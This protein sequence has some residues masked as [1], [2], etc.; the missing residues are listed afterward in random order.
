MIKDFLKDLRLLKCSFYDIDFKSKN[1]LKK[2]KITNAGE[3]LLFI[4]GTG[5][6]YLVEISSIEKVTIAEAENYY[7]K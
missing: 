7:K 2:C 1:T 3:R 5:K 4:D 6:K